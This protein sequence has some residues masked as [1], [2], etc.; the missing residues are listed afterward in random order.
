MNT[1]L[2]AFFSDV[3][4]KSGEIQ[5]GRQWQLN[6]SFF[7]WVINEILHGNPRLALDLI[8]CDMLGYD[9]IPAVNWA[10][11][12]AANLVLG[13]EK[14]CLQDVE[15]LM[16]SHRHFRGAADMLRLEI[17]DRLEQKLN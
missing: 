5:E 4:K 10:L 8:D 13:N 9:E 15:M 1:S 7:D 12:G 6:N 3:R 11:R 17:S 2:T 16:K 14:A